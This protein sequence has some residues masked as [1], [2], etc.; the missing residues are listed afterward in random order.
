MKQIHRAGWTFFT[1]LKSN[2]LVS[3]TKESGYQA[4]DTLGPPA[5][6]WSRGVEVRLQQVPFAV[7]LFK[8]VVTDG[9][10]E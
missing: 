4:L 9:S 2:R 8:L 10:I 1:T 7:K 6:G 3:P 5:S